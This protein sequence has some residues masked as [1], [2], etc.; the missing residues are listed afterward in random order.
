MK[1]EEGFDWK[2]PSPT[3]A[4]TSENSMTDE[5]IEE[6]SRRLKQAGV[7]AEA[8]RQKKRQMDDEEIRRLAADLE[9]SRK[10]LP[11]EE[12]DLEEIK[13]E[14]EA[15]YKSIPMYDWGARKES[16]EHDMVMKY[17]L[18]IVDEL[19]RCKWDAEHIPKSLIADMH[20]IH[21]GKLPLRWK[22]NKLATRPIEKLGKAIDS[23]VKWN[24]IGE[25][26]GYK[27]KHFKNDQFSSVKAGLFNVA[28]GNSE[29][30]NPTTLLLYLL[31]HRAW[32]GKKDKHDTYE[33]WYR[34]RRL[35]VASV[36][37][38]KICADLGVHE[39]TVRNWVNALH[40][41]GVIRKLKDG[42]ENVYVLGEVINNEDLFY[43]SGE[44]RGKS[45]PGSLH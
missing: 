44:I 28:R 31:Q 15:E 29:L 4:E 30:K 35:I 42:K 6:F 37:V 34:K 40:K 26:P 7:T 27:P 21:E 41:S 5:E 23:Q 22:K 16:N 33:T 3:T 13:R 12:I 43:Y 18:K 2:A 45:K 1:T 32:E 10:L 36:G 39:K 38:E 24:E 9:E 25:K 11:K 17:G 20:R 8:Q 19:R 14:S